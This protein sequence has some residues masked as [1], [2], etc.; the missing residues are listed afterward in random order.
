MSAVPPPGVS[1]REL[2][3]ALAAFAA[4]LGS[5]RVLTSEE[6]LRE[7]RD[8]YAY[9][10]W[11]EHTASA[12]VLPETVQ[13]VQAVVRIANA[14]RVPLWTFSQ[15]RNSPYGGPAPR[16]RGSV[17]V[18]LRRM[19]R[20]LE[21]NE[22]LAYA[23]VEPGATFFDLHE[24]VRASGARLWLSVPD[25]G[26]GS[27]IGNALDHGR[28]FGVYGDHAA[29]VCG[30]EVVLANGDVLR[31]GMGALPG[32][33][34]WQAYQR[35]FGPSPDGLF[36]QSNY[37][38][39]TK[40]GVWL[41]PRPECY[42]SGSVRVARESDLEP[43]VDT[44]R[45][46]LLDRTIPNYPLIGHAIGAGSRAAVRDEWYRGDGPLPEEVVE[47]IRARTGSGRWNLR[48]ALYGC[49]RVVD[50]QLRIVEGAFSR[51]PGAAT[52]GRKFAGDEVTAATEM[53]DRVQAGI[54]GL[55]MLEMLRWRGGEHGGHLD[56]SPVAPLTGRDAARLCAV[57]RPVVE[58]HGLDFAPGLIITPRCVIFISPP[59]FDTTN[60]EQ[61]RGAYEMYGELV[62]EAGRA[63]YGVYRAHLSAMDRVADQFDFNDHAQRRFNEAL[64]DALDPNGIL[65]PGKQGIW[66]RHLRG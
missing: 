8:P 55:Q 10:G 58:R 16:L 54:P 66:P 36:M 60:E 25:L 43:L 65:S 38:I 51:I 52:E 20:V 32:S 31:T 30:M 21:V 18:N 47:Q 53:G 41:M 5:D 45:P 59:I 29:A 28:G 63:G 34:A 7:F 14:H 61:T 56:F 62:A 35:G 11:D 64:K 27:V 2:A 1:E 33:R 42:V 19:N 46:L 22:E 4:A 15:G 24:A 3:G 37:G 44:L 57:L 49:E 6:D 23:L 9:A 26:W 48:F 12:A 13:E 50:A 17:L 39:V 40:M